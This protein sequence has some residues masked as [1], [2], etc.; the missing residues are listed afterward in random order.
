MKRVLENQGLV[1]HLL[2]KK[3]INY[4]DYD[5]ILQTIFKQIPLPDDT[6]RDEE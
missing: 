5:E 4:S 2:K 1:H 6:G 3:E